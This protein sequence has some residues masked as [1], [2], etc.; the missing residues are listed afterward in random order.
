MS[1][2]RSASA[3]ASALA[4]VAAAPIAN[5][6]NGTVVK[7]FPSRKRTER[8]NNPKGNARLVAAAVSIGFPILREGKISSECFLNPNREGRGGV[9]PYFADILGSAIVVVKYSDGREIA[10]FENSDDADFFRAK[11]S[12]LAD[13]SPENVTSR[14]LSDFEAAVAKAK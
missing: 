11:Y 13:C 12:P 10:R 14:T 2:R 6:D 5:T 1:A 9:F 4:K 8:N 7:T 3:S